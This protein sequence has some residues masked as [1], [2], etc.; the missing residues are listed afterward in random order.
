MT[1]NTK[2]IAIALAVLMLASATVLCM[3]AFAENQATL[4]E[5]VFVGD[6][7]TIP[8]KTL[9]NGGESKAATVTVTMP[10]GGLFGGNKIVASQAGKYLVTYSATISGKTVTE[11]T[12][13]V[14]L[15]H[16]EN[17]FVANKY[18]TAET[19][20]F[21]AG[22]FSYNG[23]LLTM[24]NNAEVTFDKVIDVADFTRADE[25]LDFMVVPSAEGKNDFA[26]LVITLTDAENSA[27]VVKISVKDGGAENLNG[28][29][30]Y[31]KIGA[32]NQQIGGYEY[33]WD[34]VNNIPGETK[35][36]TFFK[37]GT[38][39]WM[40]FRGIKDGDNDGYYSM[41][42]GLDYADKAFYVSRYW[43]HDYTVK[44]CDLDDVTLYGSDV[45][46][47][48]TSGKMKVSFS[49]SGLTSASAKVLVG[50]VCGF[51]LSMEMYEDTTAPQI[52][53]DGNASKPP[54]SVVGATYKVFDAVALDDFDDNIAV[55]TAVKYIYNGA[56]YNVN[57]VDGKFATNYQGKYVVSYVATDR[58]GNMSTKQ[59]EVYCDI[60]KPDVTIDV[61][62]TDVTCGLFEKVSV[63]D[64][65]SA[66]VNGEGVFNISAQ[67][68]APDGK[69]VR[70]EDNAFVPDQTGKY[71]LTYT[72]TDYVGNAY[73]RQFN[74]TV[75]P[76]TKPVFVAK[77]YLPLAFIYGFNYDL[78]TAQAYEGN[79]TAI[80]AK[81][82][83]DNVELNGAFTPSE[84]QT[85]NGQ[86]EIKYVARGV[87]GIAEYIATVKTV[88]PIVEQ[89]D[90]V[91]IDQSAYFVTSNATA[92]MEKDFVSVAFGKDGRFT[93]ANKLNARAASIT[94]VCADKT[95]DSVQVVLS[96]ST[97]V[98]KVVT[99]TVTYVDGK[100][101]VTFPHDGNVYNLGQK[102]ESIGITY[103][104]DTYS[105]GGVDNAV[106]GKIAYYDNGNVFEGFGD[107]V[108]I[109]VVCNTQSGA[110]LDFTNIV[111]Q[112]LGHRSAA[113]VIG[114]TDLIAPQIVADDDTNSNYNI[115]DT[116]TIPAVKAFDVLNP[117][118]SV[119]VT[120]VAPDGT[121]ILNNV[122]GTTEHSIKLDLYGTY[123]V[124]YTATDAFGKRAPYYKTIFVK[125]TESPKLEVN[126]KKIKKTYKVGDK[127][128][129]PSYTVSDN[130]GS[131]NLDVM[132]IYPDNYIVY[133]L[134]D[135]SGEITYC[136]KSEN[137]K[138]PNGLLVN[139]K[140]FK[141]NKSGVYTLRYFAYDEFYNC[142]TVDVTIVVE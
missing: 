73:T 82:Y 79:G 19:G 52:V 71:L 75:E 40:S 18:A 65:K 68:I 87:S 4:P 117:I 97:D 101:Y 56:E 85:A 92:T 118:Q 123:A 104:N 129:I 77:P 26:E 96:D 51:D 13:F 67:L 95:F 138:L 12:S 54:R 116:A 6:S 50:K 16:P 102:G 83:V 57:I 55:Q 136:L 91:Y 9:T 14:A 43:G 108:Y 24:K 34:W 106:C 89:G 21:T 49:V 135:N 59:T 137:T 36:N 98:N 29:G 124:T 60:V 23:V 45:W 105:V 86:V 126:T 64:A 141:L 139:E 53:L 93:F 94:F 58:S 112:T 132:L 46:K 90:A 15:R 109:G 130:S 128:E 134:N 31:L 25:F 32:N 115:G 33:F 61:P 122:D 63:A 140:T 30:S 78:P 76:L 127:I 22:E 107:A 70:I 48:F 5:K 80:L 7:V 103:N 88:K 74:I 133:L 2:I 72:A 110:T 69:Q 113:G 20:K 39:T 38:P 17:M 62:Q 8:D 142:V 41:N 99:V 11:Q 10:D 114:S 27:N 3:F 121:R 120:V 1:K 131:Y 47:G 66:K 119:K 28:R 100:Y 81:I 42:L 44:V 84:A 37:F 111:N 125:E 35:F